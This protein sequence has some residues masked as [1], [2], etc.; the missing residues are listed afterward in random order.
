MTFDRKWHDDI[1]VIDYKQGPAGRQKCLA[2]AGIPP[3][4]ADVLTEMGKEFGTCFSFRMGSPWSLYGEESAPKPSN[5]KAKTSNSPFT[6]GVVPVESHLFGKIENGVIRQHN[7]EAHELP[8]DSQN[9]VTLP[10]VQH[11]LTLMDVV[12]G[13]QNNPPTYTLVGTPEEIRQTNEIRIQ[14]TTNIDGLKDVI[15]T[16]QLNESISPLNIKR[17]NVFATQKGS[18]PEPTWWDTKWGDFNIKAEHSYPAY[19][20]KNQKSEKQPLMVYGIDTNST[21]KKI[22]PITGD[23]DLL[24]VTRP[25]PDYYKKNESQK[26]FSDATLNLPEGATDVINTFKPAGAREMKKNLFILDAH[27]AQTPDKKLFQTDTDLSA[28]MITNLGC[29]TPHEAYV[30]L[31]ANKKTTEHIQHIGEFLQHGAENRNPGAPSNIDSPMVHFYSGKAI[32]TRDERSLMLFVLKTK[33][34][35]EKNIFDVHPRWDMKLWGDVVEKQMQ[36]G[37]NIRSETLESYNQ[38]KNDQRI[39]DIKE[40]KKDTTTEEQPASTPSMR[41]H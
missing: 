6:R 31:A 32:I 12:A 15:V 30:I 16:L 26:L 18:V 10:Q 4:F 21:S 23:Q 1:Y 17:E 41:P 14:A 7:M 29:V 35:L 36:L 19:Y 20:S 33:G 11:K 28:K 9:N 39:Q 24:W 5:V 25:N 38:Y 37:H 27:F 40:G 3:K 22:K 8:V 2:E 13:L 34:Y